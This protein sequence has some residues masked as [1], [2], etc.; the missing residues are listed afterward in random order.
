MV[1]HVYKWDD[2]GVTTRGHAALALQD[3]THI[4]WWPSEKGEHL[5]MY[6]YTLYFDTRSETLKRCALN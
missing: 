5:L 1:V 4:S 6:M 3:G 2:D